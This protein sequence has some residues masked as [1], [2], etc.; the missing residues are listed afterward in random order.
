MPFASLILLP[1]VFFFDLTS[2]SNTYSI[3]SYCKTS[4]T[5]FPLGPLSRACK[6]YTYRALEKYND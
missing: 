2:L 5:P 4:Q 3:R 6:L 1:G